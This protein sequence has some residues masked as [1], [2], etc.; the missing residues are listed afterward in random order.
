MSCRIIHLLTNWVIRPVE[1]R[2]PIYSLSIPGLIILFG[3]LLY[4]RSAWYSLD[5]FVTSI[6]HCHVLFCDFHYIFYR[7]GSEIFSAGKPVA[8]YFYSP[9]FAFFLAIF[10]LFPYNISTIFWGIFQIVALIALCAVPGIYF[11]RKSR[12]LHFLHTFLFLTAVPVL[13]NFKWGQVSIPVILCLIAS[14]LFYRKDMRFLSALSLAV[15]TAVK[16]YAGLFIIFFLFK[17]DIRFFVFFIIFIFIFMVIMPVIFLGVEKSV[18]FYRD[19]KWGIS[20]AQP[21]VT[22]SINSQYFASVI[23]RLSGLPEST[24]IRTAMT[25]IGYIL[26]TV[27]MAAV[28]LITRKRLPDDIFRAFVLFSLSTPFILGTSWPHYFVFLPF[29]QTFCLMGVFRTKDVRLTKILIIISLIIVSILLSSVFFFNIINDHYQ[30][31]SHGSLF[32]SNLLLLTAF[33][34]KMTPLMMRRTTK[35]MTEAAL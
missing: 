7:M 20:N 25:I 33:Y 14:L 3:I 28:Y 10:A 30:Y 15:C 31:N 21:W 32:F 13:H 18:S 22:T 24:T 23:C 35:T 16:Y 9:F 12:S 17:K 27:N 26:F 6:D 19:V 34:L 1:N 29:C 2:N 4:Y 8:G 5:H 11:I